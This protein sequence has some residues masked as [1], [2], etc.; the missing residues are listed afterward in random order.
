ME[1]DSFQVVEY[2]RKNLETFLSPQSETPIDLTSNKF[3]IRY[4]Q[5]YLE[6]IDARTIVMENHYVDR[7]FLE[8]FANYYIRCFHDYSHTCRRLHFFKKEF[9]LGFFKKLLQGNPEIDVEDFQ[10]SYLGFIV[11][12][13]LPSTIIGRTCLNTYPE[14]KPDGQRFF[15]ITRKYALTLFGISLSVK[16]LAFQ[17]Q[18]AVVAAC[19][20]SAL[21]SAFQSTGVQFQHPIL[22]PG[23]ITKIANVNFPL[24]TRLF[25]N[26]GLYPEQMALA[27]RGVGLEPQYLEAR[28]TKPTHLKHCIYAYLRGKFPLILG[29][30]LVK[31]VEGTS[32]LGDGHAV[33]ITGYSL[34]ND[35]PHDLAFDQLNLK[36]SRIDKIYV[37]DDQVGPFARMNFDD[38]LVYLKS[39]RNAELEGLESISSQWWGLGGYHRALCDFLMIPLYHKV[40]IPLCCIE[41]VLYHFHCMINDV[42]LRGLRRITLSTESRLR[43]F[44]QSPL[45]WDVYLT[46]ITELKKD[47]FESDLEGITRQAILVQPMPKFLW[48]A[49]SYCGNEKVLDLLFDATDIEQGRL[50][51]RAIEYNKELSTLLRYASESK[52]LDILTGESRRIFAW[53]REQ[54]GT[55]QR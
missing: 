27:I 12:K 6:E 20:T 19:A 24:K 7:D 53:F 49:T 46:T 42:I 35:P 47:I 32:E 18:D 1:D 14:N 52:S 45:E 43:I 16:T 9:D 51:V 21:W 29:F 25:P 40:R 37:H 38:E 36:S 28:N 5:D 44:L 34:L 54:V 10:H 26:E 17:E 39:D 22:S 4:F 2:S 8:D 30:S 11:T 41:K 31:K 13:P 3:H 33:T 48:R 55:M 23:E 15:P 50:F